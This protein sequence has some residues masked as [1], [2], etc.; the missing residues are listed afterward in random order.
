[1]MKNKQ[2][3][4]L[5]RAFNSMAYGFFGT[6]IIGII[7]EELGRNLNID[8]LITYG[9]MVKYLMGPAIGVAIAYT[10]DA[11]GLTLIGG[12]IAGTIGAG[13]LVGLTPHIG[14]PVG[15]LIT[16]IVAI[17]GAMFIEKKTSFDI[18]L[19]PLVVIILSVLTSIFVAPFFM[20][21]TQTVGD[22]VNQATT[23]QPFVM[24]VIVAVVMGMALTAP[25]SSA[26][27]AIALGLSGLAAGAAAIGCG[28]Q[29]IG[30]AV[31]TKNDNNWSKTI[32]VGLG[33]SMLQF[34]NILK[35]PLIWV[36]PI[37]TSAIL[38]PVSTVVFML[39]T[40]AYGAGMGTSGLVGPLT[41]YRIMGSNYLIIIILMFFVFPIVLN[42]LFYRGML[43]LKW[44]K[45]GALKIENMA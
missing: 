32:A 21:I 19:I 31:M 14:D 4:Y 20:M 22:V 37:L 44:I 3:N 26:A 28:A 11:K 33:T 9:S 15:A 2:L 5:F 17:E 8:V 27:I 24:G 29:M 38:G 23:Y 39:Q 12:V 18:F 25:I 16:S 45:K 36:P 43:Q 40:D 34:T 10:R 35:S 42:L 41:M 6:L 30:F 1:M 13:T 7:L